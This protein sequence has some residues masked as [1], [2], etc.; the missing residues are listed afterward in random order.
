V[1]GDP[2]HQAVLVAP[3]RRA[4]EA[5]RA[6]A[7]AR[8]WGPTAAAAAVCVVL[9]LAWAPAFYGQ[10]HPVVD[11]VAY[12]EQAEQLLAGHLTVPFDTEIPAAVEHLTAPTDDG[13]VFKYLPGT[14]GLGA[15]STWLTGDVAGAR[16]AA[17]V[18]LVVATAGVAA[19][20]GWSP[21]R[22]AVAAFLVGASPIVLSLDAVLLSYV[23]AVALLVTALWL[24]LAATVRERSDRRTLL[25]LGC[26]GLVLG[27]AFLVRQVEVLAWLAVLCGWCSLRTGPAPG[28]R[29]AEVGAV[30]AGTLPG[31]VVVL[32]V[33]W[34]VTGDALH[35][36]FT[37]V[38]PDDGLGW[39]LR[40]VLPGDPLETFHL[41][42]GV[43]TTPRAT[44]DLLMWTLAGP[45]L[46]VGAA[47]ALWT[48]RHDPR[49]WLLAALVAVVPFAFWFHW[50]N[51]HAVWAGFY[52]S[53]GPF[54][55]LASVV[56][57]VLL[58]I[59][60]LSRLPRNAVLAGVAVV[61]VLQGAFL[62]E[63]LQD[64]QGRAGEP[65]AIDQ[66]A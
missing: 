66:G 43:R 2:T 1:G 34:S 6:R 53:V 61:P 14:A 29:V 23:P 11:H 45:A 19:V 63:H 12:A 3:A 41:V 56:P 44:F 52:M 18:L 58:G 40:R 49:R 64:W 22:R 38:S 32:L 51:A 15:I 48:Q 36:P 31:L 46:A 55:Y 35:L 13:R 26:A 21:S 30:L 17:L 24:V 7:A 5:P 28:R 33:S 57:L 39:G 59:D 20:L 25:L 16:I 37:V 50:A 47:V 54:Y 4:I 62:T 65:R 8:A 10:R 9:M 42:D 60:G 27:A